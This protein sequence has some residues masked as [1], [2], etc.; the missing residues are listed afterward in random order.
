MTTSPPGHRRE[1]K[2]ALTA[3]AKL[4]QLRANNREI[5]TFADSCCES[6]RPLQGS[7]SPKSGKEGFGVISQCP[8]NER[9]ESKNPHFP[10]GA[11]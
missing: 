4:Q 11:L 6:V 5:T 2:T 9:F 3:T 8:R 7:K 10:C 1:A